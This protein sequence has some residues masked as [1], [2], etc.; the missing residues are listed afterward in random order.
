MAAGIGDDAVNAR[1]ADGVGSAAALQLAILIA[2]GHRSILVGQT[3]KGVC[4]LVQPGKADET[5]GVAAAGS[6]GAH[7]HVATCLNGI[8]CEGQRHDVG[9]AHGHRL[10]VVFLD[11][12]HI[13]V[14]QTGF[15]LDVEHDF[16]IGVREDEITDS[17][18]HGV[19]VI[20]LA[21]LI[22]AAANTA[23]REI[24]TGGPGGFAN[25]VE[26]SPAVTCL[27]GGTAAE[28]THAIGLILVEPREFNPG[29][30]LQHLHIEIVLGGGGYG[31]VVQILGA[32]ILQTAVSRCA[33]GLEVLECAGGEAGG[34]VGRVDKCA[35]G[36]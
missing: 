35:G 26:I 32:G 15:L 14:C 13:Q 23:P 4:A 1:S 8:A 28:S 5:A 7:G 2:Q 11:F 9:L 3:G 24:L 25:H 30:F 33:V 17:H 27:V 16:A 20:I 19:A 29:I 34:L 31:Q 18:I 10:Y 12:Q 36:A 21:V 22:V 6:E